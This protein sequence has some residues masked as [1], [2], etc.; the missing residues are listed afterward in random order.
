MKD[1]KK[2]LR[3]CCRLNDINEPCVT[4]ELDA[5]PGKKLFFILF[6]IDITRINGTL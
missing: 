6:I 2:N 1:R 3:N 4:S 5:R